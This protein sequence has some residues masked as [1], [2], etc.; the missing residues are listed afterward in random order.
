MPDS[1]LF[2]SK[3]SNVFCPAICFH[4]LMVWTFFA[5]NVVDPERECGACLEVT[6]HS[7]VP[8]ANLY[9]SSTLNTD[10]IYSGNYKHPQK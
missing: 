4:F 6:A 9:I 3:I 7:L 10:S 2:K 5:G 1:A 8:E